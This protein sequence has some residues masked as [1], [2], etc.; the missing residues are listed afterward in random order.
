MTNHSRMS[1]LLKELK[2]ELG[3]GSPKPASSSEYKKRPRSRGI[4]RDV[5][6]KVFRRDH[7]TCQICGQSYSEEHLV[8]NHKDHNI[9]NNKMS[10]LET[11][12]AGCNM[13]E[14][15][16]YASLLRKAGPRSTISEEVRIRIAEEARRQVKMEVPHKGWRKVL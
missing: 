11:V 8:P 12:C 13:Q 9:R 4:P 10:N 1:D 16:I 14:G 2:G 15:K 3:L 7:Y 6:A 5:R